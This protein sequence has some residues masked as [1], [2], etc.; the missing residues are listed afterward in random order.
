MSTLYK[1]TVAEGRLFLREPMSVAL[2]LV[3][4]TVLLLGLGAIPIL[5]EPSP[6]FDGQRFVDLF[7]PSAL[8]LGIGVVALQHL[9]NVIAG[10]RE[11]GI[12]RR[13]STT[14]VPPVTL[15]IAQLLVALTAVVVSAVLL[16][17]SAWLVLDVAPPQ[18][19]LG[20]AVAVLVGF[21]AVLAIGTLI[22][23]VTPSQRVA[24][25]VSTLVYMVA[26]FASGVFLPRFLMPDALARLGD[27]TPPG[28]QA[29][30]DAW[31]GQPPTLLQLGIMA[32]VAAAA[33]TAA[34]KL[35]RWE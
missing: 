10:Y 17:V 21:G 26:M 35:F 31:T 9:P 6:E 15:L 11:Q 34:A 29:L 7:A 18:H 25:G 22:A 13:L 5:R 24:T 28:V 32:L 1:L 8:V 2:G 4:P 14:P 27:V 12:L 3:F 20:F 19:P 30:L 16:I 33:A 23:A